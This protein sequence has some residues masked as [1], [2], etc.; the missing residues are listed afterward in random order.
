VCQEALHDPGTHTHT[1][2]WDATAGSGGRWWGGRGGGI[3]GGG[4]KRDPSDVMSHSG[5][6]LTV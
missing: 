6:P 4:R 2:Y 3:M 5:R 1:Q